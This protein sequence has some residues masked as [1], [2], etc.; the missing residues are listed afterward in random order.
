[1]LVIPLSFVPL[2]L[3]ATRL[4]D[5][6]LDLRDA[7]DLHPAVGED[8]FDRSRHETIVRSLIDLVLLRI[9]IMH[10]VDRI[11]LCYGAQLTLH[12]AANELLP[13]S[14]T[15]LALE[16]LGIVRPKNRL[17]FVHPTLHQLKGDQLD[18]PSVTLDDVGVLLVSR[19]SRRGSAPGGDEPN[20]GLGNGPT[21]H[22]DAVPYLWG[23]YAL[24]SSETS[25][26]NSHEISSDSQ[27]T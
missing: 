17:S 13:G 20:G 3:D 25:D 1:M 2:A 22:I 9:K 6:V 8:E 16:E 5:L 7:V 27:F 11:R 4:V 21:A 15:P 18:R 14:T 26:S 19:L 23:S 10:D 24:T 12:L